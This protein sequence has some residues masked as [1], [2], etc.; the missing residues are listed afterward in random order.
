VAGAIFVSASAGLNALF[1]LRT[2]RRRFCIHFVFKHNGA[3]SNSNTKAASSRRTPK[4]IVPTPN[5][6][7]PS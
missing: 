7:A 6:S 4:L 1:F 2:A 5:L 3:V